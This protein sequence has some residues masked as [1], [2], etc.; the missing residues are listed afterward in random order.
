ME[1]NDLDKILKEPQDPQGPSFRATCRRMI[2]EFSNFSDQI[3]AGTQEQLDYALADSEVLVEHKLQ[4]KFSP[5]LIAK[6]IDANER[7]IN[8]LKEDLLNMNHW[9]KYVE[10]GLEA[11][12]NEAVEGL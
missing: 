7:E 3:V 6:K 5:V 10:A 11:S 12:L 9:I 4:K 1:V 2:E 8:T